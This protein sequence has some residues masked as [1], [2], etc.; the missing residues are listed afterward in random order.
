VE[1]PELVPGLSAIAV[2]IRK[3]CG[4]FDADAIGFG[5]RPL[6]LSPRLHII[7]LIGDHA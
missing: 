1:G 3:A 5:A 4:W 7:E 2:T 6:T